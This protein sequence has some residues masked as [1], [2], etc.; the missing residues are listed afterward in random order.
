MRGN[1]N[2]F[3]LLILASALL[4]GCISARI[5]ET[6]EAA[7]GIAKTDSVVILARSHISGN[8]TEIKFV[9]CVVGKVDS[10]MNELNVYPAGQFIDDLFPWFEPRTAPR[11]IADLSALMQ[12]PDVA[13]RIRERNVRYIIWVRGDTDKTNSGGGMS[14]AVSLAG[15]G[16]FGL[17]WWEDTATYQATVWDLTEGK[18]SG[19]VSA[20]LTGTSAIPALIVPVPLIA[21][22][23][24]AACK[25]LARQLKSF[26]TE[27]N[28]S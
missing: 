18:K 5:E 14:C 10:G 3:I 9:N 25:G 8:E 15:G 22:T 21:R 13:E 12:K 28:V 11:T 27:D 24:A 1:V 16:C 2:S 17:T 26:I 20:N 6:K 7:T 4:S 19:V 23:R